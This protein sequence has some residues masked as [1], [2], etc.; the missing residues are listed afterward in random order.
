[1]AISSFNVHYIN[2]AGESVTKNIKDITP[3]ERAGIRELVVMNNAKKTINDIGDFTAALKG[4][5][6]LETLYTP[7]R[8]NLRVKDLRSNCPRL[9]SVVG[10]SRG[11]DWVNG[12]SSNDADFTT[13]NSKAQVKKNGYYASVFEVAR[14]GQNQGGLDDFLSASRTLISDTG[15]GE[16]S[17]V[18][19]LDAKERIKPEP[20]PETEHKPSTSELLIMANNSIEDLRA[21]GVSLSAEQENNLRQHFVDNRGITYSEMENFVNSDAFKN[22]ITSAIPEGED[23]SKIVGSATAATIARVRAM[24]DMF[25]TK[26]TMLDDKVGR[27][28]GKATAATIGRLDAMGKDL[29]GRIDELDAR[30][31]SSIGKAT[32][33]TIARVHNMQNDM[34]SGFASIQDDIA[35]LDGK[36]GRSVGKATAATIARMHNMQNDMA[37]GFASVQDDVASLD[38]KVGRSVGKSTAQVISRLDNM[39]RN[40]SN[41]FAQVAEQL[42]TLAGGQAVYGEI[43]NILATYQTNLDA[44]QAQM[45]AMAGA[46]ANMAQA[47]A[48]AATPAQPQQAPTYNISNVTG[49]VTIING[50]ITVAENGSVNIGNYNSPMMSAPAGQAQAN[51]VG[52]TPVPPANPVSGNAN[53]VPPAPPVSG[54]TPTNPV[55]PVGGTTPPVSGGT[56]PTNP[57]PP[58]GGSGTPAKPPVTPAPAK[59]VTGVTP[60]PAKPTQTAQVPPAKKKQV[61]VL[62]QS[63]KLMDMLHEPK[64]PWY[65]RMGRFIARHPFR[66]ALIGLGAG[67]LVATGVGAIAAGGLG[68]ALTTANMFFPT[69]ATGAVMGAGVG[70]AGSLVSRITPAGRRQRKYARFMKKYNKAMKKK[71]KVASKTASIQRTQDNIQELRQKQRSGNLFAKLGVYKAAKG[72]QRKVLRSHRRSLSKAKASYVETVDKAV[73]AK[74]K[75]NDLESKKTMALG[76]YLNK[77]HKL[78]NKLA[79][80]KLEPEEYADDMADLEFEMPGLHQVSDDYKTGDTE[81]KELIEGI[82]D[83]GVSPTALSPTALSIMSEIKKRNSKRSLKV[84]TE[85]YLEDVTPAEESLAKKDKALAAELAKRKAEIAK[86]R[87]EMKDYTDAKNAGIDVDALEK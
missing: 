59:P 70:L 57:T 28:V 48:P 80:G 58:T 36:V 77:K 43:L 21:N 4:F 17:Y 38:S 35:S 16:P 87:A 7:S 83:V 60:P 81:V 24:E 27:S 52:G 75:L 42:K 18:V 71:A 85:E 6:A 50:N 30:T 45:S 31:T 49:N 82:A 61:K 32:A 62:K 2:N 76:G 10:L 69:I 8:M 20:A 12:P 19:M 79:S 3:E 68:A 23:V 73:T 9:S 1:M 86:Q 51:P 11:S 47:S 54:T 26:L 74:Q 67:A 41:N 84:E 13:L 15:M 44:I 29:N 34:A 53:P 46:M 25:A 14:D 64:L 33:A 40:N 72:I 66:S 78:D 55:P 22:I 5:D 56:N 39:D 37:S 65:K 63:Q